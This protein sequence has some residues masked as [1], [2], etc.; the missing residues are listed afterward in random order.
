SRA[1]GRTYRGSVQS[2]PLSRELTDELRRVSA[3]EGVT[4]YVTLL[5]TLQTLM[6]RYTGGE[7]LVVGSPIANRNRSEIQE[8]IGPF[9]NTLAL[10]T[11]VEGQL[12]L[13]ELLSR[14]R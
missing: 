1:G 6:H 12:T 3:S 11:R 4:L 8:M 7:D 13:R 10:R 5:A 14:V 2:L 9:F